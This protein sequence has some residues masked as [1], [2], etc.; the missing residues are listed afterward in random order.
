[1]TVRYIFYYDINLEDLESVFACD[2]K[3]MEDKDSIPDLLP[4]HMMASADGKLSGFSVMEADSDEQ[5]AKYIIQFAKAGKRNMRA[6]PIWE[7]SKTKEIWR[8]IKE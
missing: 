6:V 8:Q 2:K 3:R 5:I 7:T 4:P 1:M